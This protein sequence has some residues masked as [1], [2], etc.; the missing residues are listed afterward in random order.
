MDSQLFYTIQA[1]ISAFP[2]DFGYL[3]NHWQSDSIFLVQD[4][5]MIIKASTSYISTSW[6]VVLPTGGH[7]EKVH[8]RSSIRKEAE[9]DYRCLITLNVM[10][11]AMT[12]KRETFRTLLSEEAS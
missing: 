1:L 2:C 3:T 9:V 6:E 5:Y 7:T 10:C 11:L 12:A 8:G 4:L